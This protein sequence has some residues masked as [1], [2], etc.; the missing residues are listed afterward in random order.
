[1]TTQRDIRNQI[2]YARKEGVAEGIAQGI[3]KGEARGRAEGASA[4]TDEIARNFKA[5][6]IPL[7]QIAQATGLSQEQVQEL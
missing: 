7:D 6:G 3:A 5:M 1:M 4:R 2:A